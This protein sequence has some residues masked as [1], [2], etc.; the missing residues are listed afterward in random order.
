VVTLSKRLA[1]VAVDAVAINLALF[2]ALLLRFD[3]RI[4]TQYLATYGSFVWPTTAVAVLV[5]YL[6]G[7]YRRLWRYASLTDLATIVLG[8]G[9]VAALQLVGFYFL[10]AY[11]FP[12]SVII[13]T[14]LLAMVIIGGSRLWNRLHWF[15]KNRQINGGK[16][17]EE[18][19]Q[20]L[21]IG[22]GD[23]GEMVLRELQKRPDLGLKVVGFIDD[24]P[25]K[26]G[27]SIHGVPILG[28]VAAIPVLVQKHQIQQI[29]IAIPSASRKQK[30]EI[31]EVC[32]QTKAKLRIL[33]GVYEL[34]DGK[35]TINHIKEV[36]I[37]DLLGRDPA[38]VNIE[39]IAGY[40]RGEVVLVTGAGGSIGSELCRQIARFNP[41]KLLLLGHGENSIF[42]IHNELGCLFPQLNILPVIAD[43]QDKRRI[44]EI[45]EKYKPAVVF[46]AAA[47][48]HV[49]L[50]EI[51]PTEAVKNNVLG[52]LNMAEAADRYRAKRFALIS[53]DKAVNPKSVM[54][55]TKRAAE[56]I[57]QIIGR[58]SST[59]FCAVR[60]GNVL[61][62]RGSVVPLFKKQ[63]ARG[64]PV[65]VT[66]PEMT[67]YF[68]TI[69]EAV[70][71]IIQAGAMAEKGEIYI[72]DMG[73][74]VKIVDLA[75]D[76]IRLSGFEPGEDI[77]IEF[78]GIRPGEKLEERLVTEEE[79]MVR[80]KH[81][82][83]F[84][85]CSTPVSREDINMLK[86]LI[87]LLGSRYDASERL[88][89]HIHTLL[90]EG[91]PNIT[92]RSVSL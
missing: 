79:G 78:T 89:K 13:L 45:F 49:P 86:G 63:I 81:E 12:R 92:N 72:L 71:L 87:E 88:G 44:D 53:T 60:F 66:H 47:H 82:Q 69:S 65:T 42:E 56:I 22:A 84:V 62:S 19:E 43:I 58:Q 46:H 68:M 52:T 17:L 21:I 31:I 18:W 29:I 1:L 55:A 74:P 91:I 50:M 36:E 70:Q 4:P 15:F 24:D 23:A 90:V 11:R 85:L 37:E 75:R 54:G 83:I 35:V 9:S 26:L 61:G 2:L 10:E 67:R 80:T 14:W 39:E 40:L 77:K 38:E 30:K 7:F 5:F 76:M 33:P 20:V 25:E 28:H 41:Q 57:V 16:S 51:N 3:G 6:C 34:I 64:G 8:T 48:K 73:E 32:R 59:R 27:R